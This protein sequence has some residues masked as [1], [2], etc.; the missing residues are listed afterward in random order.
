MYWLSTLTAVH[1]V[2]EQRVG[3]ASALVNMAQQVGAAL[4]LAVFTTI[5]ISASN[6]RLAGAAAAL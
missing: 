1:D 5:S 2:G 4:E 6:G 3:V